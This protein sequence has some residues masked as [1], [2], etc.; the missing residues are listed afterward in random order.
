MLL[1]KLDSYEFSLKSTTFIQSYLNK[2]MQK[3]NVNNKFN[4]SENIYSGVL[5]GSILELLESS[6]IFSLITFSAS[7]L[8]I[9]YILRAEISIKFKN[10]WKKILKYLR[11]GSMT[12]IWSLFLVNANSWALE[13]PIKMRYLPI[14]KYDLKNYY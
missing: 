10:I 12:I 9:L 3:A 14:M 6:L 8:I 5:Q 4:A 13:K 2:R 1:A 7:W 11:T